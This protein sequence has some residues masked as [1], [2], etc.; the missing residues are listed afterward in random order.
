M[1]T[2][3]D[4][5]VLAID[6]G[7]THCRF[8]L[9]RDGESVVAQSGPANV[10]TDFDGAV[11]QLNAGLAALSARA[12]CDL[13]TLCALPAFVGLAG[14]ISDDI[15]ARL[16]AALPLR[17]A[18]FS[19]DRAAAVRGALGDQTGFVA[20]FGTGS[21]FGAQR[22]DDICLVGGWGSILGDPASAQWV[23]KQ[24][25]A[26][27]LE[28]VDGLLPASD[29]ATEL[30]NRC[31]GPAGIVSFAAQATPTAFGALAPEVTRHAAVKDHMAVGILTRGADEITRTLHSL[32]WAPGKPV[33]LTGGIGPTF[34]AYLPADI[35]ADLAQPQ[36]TPLDGA[37]SLAMAHSREVT[38]GRG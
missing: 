13:D 17:A 2:D 7:G 9:W 4:T 31:G 12:D 38:H 28:V 8:A 26:R 32:G 21:F 3:S 6:G 24:A 14:M 33:C 11:A 15:S 10:A 20:H 1:R 35:A 16:H 34:A 5:R 22:G 37:V 29:L 18:K 23:G 30:L 19:D 25:L 27:T 36:G